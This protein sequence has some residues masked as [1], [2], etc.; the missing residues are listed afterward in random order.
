M[1]VEGGERI[2]ITRKG[3]LDPLVS[4]D[5][6]SIYY[7]KGTDEGGVSGQSPWRA[8]RKDRFSARSLL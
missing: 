7:L 8:V 3:G 4:P 6:K 1:P 2:Q 5:G